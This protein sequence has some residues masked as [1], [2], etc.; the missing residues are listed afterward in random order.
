MDSVLQEVFDFVKSFSD[1]RVRQVT[2]NVYEL[3]NSEGFSPDGDRSKCFFPV[4]VLI[5]KSS[6]D[7]E[8][9]LQCLDETLENVTALP[10]KANLQYRN[11]THRFVKQ[12]RVTATHF[13]IHTTHLLIGCIL[14][15]AS[16]GSR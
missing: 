2:A 11:K 7:L 15:A 8:M 3:V 12:R 16:S 10:I 4:R 13:T 9:Q 6:S 14:L 5:L 1:I